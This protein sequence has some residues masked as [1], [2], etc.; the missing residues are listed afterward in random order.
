MPFSPPIGKQ[1]HAHAPNTIMIIVAVDIFFFWGWPPCGAPVGSLIS[2]GGVLSLIGLLYLTYSNHGCGKNST[3]LLRRDSTSPALRCRA[4]ARPQD[5]FC[6]PDPPPTHG[7]ALLRRFCVLRSHTQG[8]L[9][10]GACQQVGQWSGPLNIKPQNPPDWLDWDLY[11]YTGP[12]TG[13][14]ARLIPVLV[15]Q[16]TATGAPSIRRPTS[17]QEAW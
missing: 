2:G 14:N 3:F 4:A 13:P 11:H 5:H 1:R 8:T 10:S 17:R 15:A 7:Q 6:R 16:P 9:L 12:W